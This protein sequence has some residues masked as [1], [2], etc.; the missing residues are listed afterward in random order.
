MEQRSQ[1]IATTNRKCRT[2]ATRLSTKRITPTTS[3]NLIRGPSQLPSRSSL[4][5]LLSWIVLSPGALR[6]ALGSHSQPDPLE[7][8]EGEPVGHAR[9]IVDH[10]DVGIRV[11]HAILRQRLGVGP[12]PVA[13]RAQGGACAVDLR[14]DLR[15]LVDLLEQERPGLQHRGPL[16]VAH[17]HLRRAEARLA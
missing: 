10:G 17:L 14:G 9:H 8:P 4:M 16:L 1:T 11:G 2:W 15:P 6:G 5:A 13:D 7:L 3:A 12:V